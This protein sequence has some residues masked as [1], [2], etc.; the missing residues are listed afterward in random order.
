M[1]D[2]SEFLYFSREPV[3]DVARMSNAHASLSPARVDPHR[4]TLIATAIEA[5]LAER[6]WSTRTLD[7][8]SCFRA[9]FLRRGRGTFTATSSP[10]L[11]LAA[12]QILWLPFEAGG[13]FRLFAGGDGAAILVGE[14]VVFRIVGDNPLAS[15]IRPLIERVLIAD[16]PV[17][18]SALQ[19]IDA[20]FAGLARES[21]DP[22]PG[23]PAMTALYLGLILM[24]LWRACAVDRESGAPGLGAPIA[25]RFRQL[26]ELHYRDNLSVDA[27]ARA[28][29][30]TRG[31]L[32]GACLRALGRAP[33]RIVHERLAVEARLR[34]RQTAQPI[35]QVAFGLGFRDP[36]YF[37]RFFHRMSGLS[38][39]AY[40]RSARLDPP[41]EATSFEAW[42]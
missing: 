42:P 28:L 29:G 13:E 31:H 19:E 26:V 34:L 15:Q 18:A 25:Q 24:R 37:S 7:G 11:E 2:S 4:A 9:F 6:T 41:R 21:R 33:Q 5:T 35:E 40:R 3:S 12:P 8:L 23:A 32:H 16:A 39:G 1:D 22:G 17:S 38:P 30:V 27:F 36:A 20:L 10:A 14:D